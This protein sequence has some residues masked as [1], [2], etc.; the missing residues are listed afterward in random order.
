MSLW[1][2]LAFRIVLAVATIAVGGF[3]SATLVRYAPGFGTDEQQLDARLSSGSLQAIRAA[4]ND[5]RSI[6]SYY[7][8]AL[9]RTLRGDLG[10]SRS[11]QRSVRELLAE[12]GAVTG[13]IV[14]KGLAAAW[15][16]ALILSMATWLARSA[17]IEATCAIASGL[18]LCLPAG[19]MA[20]LVILLNGPGYLALALVVFPKVHRY[21][22]A[23]VQATARMPHIITARARGVSRARIVLWHVVPVIRREVLAL[24][25]ASV[26]L[27]VG[28]AI[29]V[30]ALCGIPGVGQLAW[31]SA[32]ARDL[33]V[34]INISLLVIACTVLA[35]SGADLLAEERRCMP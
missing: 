19:A 1:R 23:L 21:L 26:G 4:A 12:R 14:A 16:T 35:N 9:R 3:V 8:G 11:L 18:L 10:T 33:P 30:E 32:L 15:V 5:E 24:A 20:L 22:S 6:A 25:G 7:V 28:A 13:G 2:T 27:A 29:P 31:Q 34:L 17:V